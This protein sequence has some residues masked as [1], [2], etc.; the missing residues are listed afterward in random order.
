M[1]R[2]RSSLARVWAG[3]R[4]SRRRPGGAGSWRGARAGYAARRSGRK[5]RVI[6]SN[7]GCCLMVRAR[8]SMRA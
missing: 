5:G 1:S 3:A 6:S 7:H 2:G 8:R 4:P